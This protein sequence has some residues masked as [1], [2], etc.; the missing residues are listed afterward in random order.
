MISR[1]HNYTQTH[2]HTQICPHILM[3]HTAHTHT[4]M[5]TPTYDTH[6]HTHIHTHTHTR[7]H[8]HTHTT[9]LCS[10]CSYMPL[11]LI[12]QQDGQA[13]DCI[14]LNNTATFVCSPIVKKYLL[15]NESKVSTLPHILPSCDLM[16]YCTFG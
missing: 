7:T 15:C 6:T 2:T 9:V 3:T 16:I 4:N 10:G 8:T 12:S 11:I 13:S 5:P 1:T 14:Q